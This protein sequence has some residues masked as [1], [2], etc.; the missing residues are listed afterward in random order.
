[1]NNLPKT[2]SELFELMHGSDSSLFSLKAIFDNNYYDILKEHL[3]ENKIL[4]EHIRRISDSS[5]YIFSRKWN[6]CLLVNTKKAENKIL[7][8]VSQE[9]YN[10]QILNSL[11]SEYN[12]SPY[13]VS[14]IRGGTFNGNDLI[15]VDIPAGRF[16]HDQREFN[17]IGYMLRPS[18]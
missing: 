10:L 6:Y 7:I 4:G 12:I 5:F 16:I 15:I 3:I 1:M 11:L 14:T 2:T 18:V 17:L 13:Q 9:L 8:E